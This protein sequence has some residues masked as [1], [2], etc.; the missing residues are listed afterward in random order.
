VKADT[1]N[2]ANETFNLYLFDPSGDLLGLATATI[3]NDD[4]KGGKK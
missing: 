3:V 4:T 2:E 1:T